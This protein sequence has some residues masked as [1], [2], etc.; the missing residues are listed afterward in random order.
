MN[1]SGRLGLG[2][3]VTEDGKS[4][5]PN[6]AA[7]EA[8]L[9]SDGLVTW[10]LVGNQKQESIKWT[11]HEDD[12]IRTVEGNFGQ[13]DKHKPVDLEDFQDGG[14]YRSIVKIQS[15]WGDERTGKW[16]MGT[17]WL[18]REDI[19]ITAGHN[20][21]SATHKCQAS[22]IQC[23]IGYRGHS[24]ISDSSVQHRSA[25]NVVTTESWL[26][27]H[28]DRERR[29]LAL[30][31]VD[32]A[33]AGNLRLFRYIDTPTAKA[34][35]SIIVVGYPGDKSPEALAGET[36]AWMCEARQKANYDHD[37]SAN[38]MI[39]YNMDTYGGLAIGCHQSANEDAL[40]GAFV[41]QSGAPILFSDHNGTVVIGTHCYGATGGSVS[42]G[43]PIGG[44]HGNNYDEFIKL[45][46][47]SKRD[48]PHRLGGFQP[49]FANPES[50][51]G[52]SYRG[53]IG[54]GSPDGFWDMLEAVLGVGL[55]PSRE[56]TTLGPVGWL[57]ATIAGGMIGVLSETA[58]TTGQEGF[59]FPN[60]KSK[61]ACI[62]RAQLAESALQ[63][64]IQLEPS[65]E[66]ERIMSSMQKAQLSPIFNDFG[67]RLAVSQWQRGVNVN[68]R[69][70]PVDRELLKLRGHGPTVRSRRGDV[71]LA[72]LSGARTRFVH[73]ADDMTVESRGLW[74][75]DMLE[76]ALRAAKPIVSEAASKAVSR[77]VH[78]MG[79]G[80]EDA[81]LVPAQDQID[82]E[83]D[84]ILKRVVVAE[85]ALQALEDM[86]LRELRAL[87]VVPGGT[88]RESALDRLMTIL[89]QMG[90]RATLIAESTMARLFTPIVHRLW[91]Q[92]HQD[93][94]HAVPGSAVAD[95]DEVPGTPNE[96]G[97]IPPPAH[98]PTAVPESKHV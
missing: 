11:I 63:C 54:D 94:H 84:R 13:E 51:L 26:G 47:P 56:R 23:W 46:E 31:Q 73:N 70:K 29:D 49:K 16:T 77:T 57:M 4:T 71:L 17:G 28:S 44:E 19:V 86:E 10:S 5:K 79:V 21:F 65:Q 82:V 40:L 39:E 90:P 93:D 41:G 75:S 20:V 64:V 89:Q 96:N 67:F 18:V 59:I 81:G 85:T 42:S 38:H 74:L 91:K 12:D 50:Q 24:L 98:S 27:Q 14:K 52:S 35:G 2:A 95:P 32:K 97:N 22:R 6:K 9:A 66:R 80:H 48:E 92:S 69:A 37:S 58:G 25:L 1:E 30:I 36:G 53:I 33:F 8:P 3:A 7:P 87:R 43:S 62:H 76:S 60:G 15:L 88:E 78:A 45:V 72:F 83:M 34:N 55:Y 61:R 68:P